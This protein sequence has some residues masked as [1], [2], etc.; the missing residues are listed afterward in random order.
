MDNIIYWDQSL[1]SDFFT[2]FLLKSVIL[3]IGLFNKKYIYFKVNI[4]NSIMVLRYWI[5]HMSSFVNFDV[6]FVRRYYLK[7]KLLED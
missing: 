2:Y 5:Q 4:L 6:K 7:K 3:T 1:N